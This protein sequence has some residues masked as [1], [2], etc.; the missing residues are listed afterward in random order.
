MSTF[1]YLETE[2]NKYKYTM[3]LI[4]K[5]VNPRVNECFERFNFLKRVQKENESFKH[6]LTECKYLVR[7]C[8]YNETDP[9][10]T[11]ED[12]VLRDKIVIGIRNPTTREALLRIEK[13]T[14]EKAIK[15]CRTSEQSKQQSMQFE[16]EVNVNAT[17]KQEKQMKNFKKFKSRKPQENGQLKCR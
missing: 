12:K 7:T 14:L 15:F 16:S 6:F 11:P 1:V 4:D 3:A 10:R 9:N 2:A 8:N 5:Y 13:L 17:T